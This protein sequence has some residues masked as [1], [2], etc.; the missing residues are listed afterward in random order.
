MDPL[1]L[2]WLNLI[3]RWAHV[4]A[5]IMWIGDSFLFMFLDRNLEPPRRPREGDV[6]GELWL[7]HGGGF[8]EVVKRNS[9]RPEEL[10][11]RLH[12]FKWESYSTW[13]SGFFL[14]TLVYYF[15]GQAVLAREGG[16]LSHGQAVALSLGLLL[17]AVAA[18]DLLC[19]TVLLEHVA[20]F[21]LVGLGLVTACAWGLLEVF[22]PR[23][24]FLQV[25]AMIATVMSSNVL[26]RIIPA[27]RRMLEA[28][29]A[30]APVDTSQGVRGKNRSA[31]NHYLTL[32]V[33]VLMLSHHFP[34][35][36]GGQWPWLT[37]ALL[38]V[39]GVGVK[40]FMIERMAM[41]PAQLWGTVAVI[42]LMVW[43]T[44]PPSPSASEEEEAAKVAAGPRVG[45]AQ[46]K[47]ILETRCVACHATR[48]TN[49]AFAAPPLGIS[50]ES[51]RQ[52]RAQKDRI[53]ARTVTTRTMPP[54]NLTGMTEEE[55]AILAAWVAQGADLKAEAAPV[56]LAPLPDAGAAPPAA[57]AATRSP[58]EAARE[59]FAARCAVCHGPRGAGDGAAAASLVPRPRSFSDKAWQ[60]QVSDDHLRKVIAEG[61]AAVGK[62]AA[63]PPN[64]D[65]ATD[66]DALDALVRLVRALGG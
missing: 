29:R 5:A 66:R 40:A 25:G 61:G 55:R 56:T 23:A 7:T 28:T 42:G 1:L 62:S 54:G 57:D 27:Q 18:Y 3:A 22:T 15:G 46:V 9:L 34:A 47:G 37:L 20:G 24:V 35:I 39:V 52:I 16:P 65:L 11:A 59:V 14:L 60:A 50:L 2:E 21:A 49:P 48:P 17:A 19:R 13:I 53:V 4:V 30:G 63:M 10:P 44:L 45:F 41:P 64:P 12:W 8:Y 58:E 32:P 31:H 33:V 6:K 43:T 38:C 26:L 36:Y 51:P